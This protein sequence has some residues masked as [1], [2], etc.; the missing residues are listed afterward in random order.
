M[1]CL[2]CSRQTVYCFAGIGQ[3]LDIVMYYVTIHNVL[4]TA[5]LSVEITAGAL[6]TC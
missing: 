3:L 5:M 6:H 2:A 4:V 1:Q